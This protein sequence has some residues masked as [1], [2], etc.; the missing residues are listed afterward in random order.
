[1]PSRK[2]SRK[3]NVVTHA[4]NSS[5]SGNGSRRMENLRPA[6]A[7]L[8]RL[9][10]KSQKNPKGLGSVAQVVD[11]FSARGRPWASTTG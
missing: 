8:G 7:K 1:M 9:Y 6:W 2:S 11:T 3:A 4:C 5:Y 10:L